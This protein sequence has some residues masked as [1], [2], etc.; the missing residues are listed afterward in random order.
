MERGYEL[1]EKCS[2]APNFNTMGETPH[3][4]RYQK[5]LESGAA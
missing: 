4:K 3:Y 1:R 2:L 5:L